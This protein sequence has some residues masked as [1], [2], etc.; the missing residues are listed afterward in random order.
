MTAECSAQPYRTVL[1][2]LQTGE[3]RLR[4]RVNAATTDEFLL[5]ADWLAAGITDWR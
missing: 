5:P 1:Q 2:V 3:Q 4:R